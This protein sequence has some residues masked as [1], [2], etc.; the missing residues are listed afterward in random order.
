M[1]RSRHLA[2][3]SCLL[4]RG[5]EFE[6]VHGRDH[7]R[8]REEGVQVLRKEVGDADGADLAVGVELFHRFPRV[9]E[10]P[11]GRHRPVDQV[12]V[13]EV[14]AE[15]FAA[16][17]ERLVGG[18]L[19]AVAELGGDED[20]LARNAGGGDGGARRRP[21][22]GRPRRCR[23]GGSRPPA[24]PRRCAVFLPAAPGRRRSRAAGS[25]TPLL[26]VS[27]GMVV[28]C[29]WDIVSSSGRRAR[30]KPLSC[31]LC[32]EPMHFPVP[33]QQACLFLF[34]LGLAVLPSL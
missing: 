34:F 1:P 32:I 10:E 31:G 33:C 28:W 18:A 25:G 8:C 16:V 29:V 9:G 5:V 22:C 27:C 14:D 24:R 30:G 26:R 2:A 6:L 15:C 11:L 3:S 7:I 20:F 12:E 17:L 23:C 19:F 13:H 21:R 4:E